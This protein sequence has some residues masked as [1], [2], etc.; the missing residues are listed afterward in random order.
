MTPKGPNCNC[1]CI[2][3]NGK[4]QRTADSVLGIIDLKC[5]HVKMWCSTARKNRYHS[6]SYL[7]ILSENKLHREKHPTLPKG[8]C[9]IFE[10]VFLLICA[11]PLSYV[12]GLELS[13]GRR[14]F[15][16]SLSLKDTERR[17]Q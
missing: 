4:E 3:L 2:D 8:L 16:F 17:F 11:W 6:L 14:Y 15:D 5:E 10:C 7:H 9:C 12:G 1:P 13:S